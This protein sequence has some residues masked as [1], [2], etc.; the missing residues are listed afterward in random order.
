MEQ[1]NLPGFPLLFLF[2]KSAGCSLWHPSATLTSASLFRLSSA[3]RSVRSIS[4]S[5]SLS[6][7]R[8]S[9][10]HITLSFSSTSLWLRL[11]CGSWCGLWCRNWFLNE[12]SVI[13]FYGS[14]IWIYW[15]PLI[16]STSH[17]GKLNEQYKV[18]CLWVRL[19][20]TFSSVQPIS[21]LTV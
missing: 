18:R 9:H 14:F 1:E 12:R 19:C 8:L 4:R 6:K 17:F 15:C 21:L 20:G 3:H 5:L 2:E 13:S 16:H 7:G 10:Y 11:G